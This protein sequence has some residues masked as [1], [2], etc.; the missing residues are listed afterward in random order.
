MSEHSYQTLCLVIEIHR[1][2]VLTTG[3]D[4]MK[5]IYADLAKY[6]RWAIAGVFS[7]IMVAPMV[8]SFSS[9]I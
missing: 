9:S 5:K 1:A 2:F 4:Q 6:V 8:A 3:G 7:A